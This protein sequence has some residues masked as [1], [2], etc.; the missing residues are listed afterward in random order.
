MK[1][2]HNSSDCAKSGVQF[3]MET[4]PI[5]KMSQWFLRFGDQALGSPIYQALSRRIAEDQ[6][7][8]HLAS[9]AGTQQPAPNLFLAAIHY[10]LL[11]K[12]NEVLANYYPSLGGTFKDEPLFFASFKEFCTKN[13]KEI[14]E[15]LQTRLVQTN[16]VQRC[17]LLYPSLNFIAQ[18]ARFKKLG[19]LDVGCAGGLNFLMDQ[20]QIH[21]S[22]GTVYGSSRSSLKLICESRGEKLPTSVDLEIASRSGIDLNPINFLDLDQQLWNLALIWPDQLDRINR[23]KLAVNLLK[24][25]PIQFL[26]GT[27]TTLLPQVLRDLPA[28]HTACVM[29]SFTLNQF[30]VNERA[31]FEAV[32][33]QESKHREI[34]RVSLEWL[35]T[36]NPELVISHYQNS[37][38][39]KST[40]RAECHGHGEWIDWKLP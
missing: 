14:S 39:L 40:L 21:Y 34:W 26:K 15:L 18:N 37:Q 20:V 38:L 4:P 1:N 35:G 28:D 24:P 10:C 3:G 23:F 36:K 7:L 32:L 5:H 33:M 13:Q 29:H 9:M 17:A 25:L 31:E 8:L 27:G 12:P 11:K 2:S 19:L 22:D 16:E 6:D 30:S